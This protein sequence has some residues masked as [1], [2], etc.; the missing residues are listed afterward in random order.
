[1]L[2]KQQLS[3]PV[4]LRRLWLR[5]GGSVVA[6]RLGENPDVSVLSIESGEYR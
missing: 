6:A 2:A 3:T 4:R 5:V 1:M